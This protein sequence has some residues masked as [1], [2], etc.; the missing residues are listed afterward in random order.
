MMCHLF[1]KKQA[2]VFCFG[3]SKL[4]VVLFLLL[5]KSDLGVGCLDFSVLYKLSAHRLEESF[6][7]IENDQ[8]L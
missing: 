8:I 2:I 3:R 5:I 1:N 7:C 4:R 6:D